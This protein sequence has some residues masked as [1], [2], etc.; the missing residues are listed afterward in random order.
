[1]GDNKQPL[2]SIVTPSYNQGQFIEETIRSVLLQN[3]PNIEYIIVDGGSTDNSLDIIKKYASRL[4]WFVS[5]KDSGQ[6]QAI[7]KGFQQ[8]K[9]KYV[10][11][12]NSDDIYLQGAI[13]KAVT[14]LEKNRNLGL[15]Y[16]N[17]LSIDA[18]THV[19]NLMHFQDWKLPDLMKFRII[20]QPAV[21]MR[22]VALEKTGFLD[23]QFSFLMDHHLWTRIA[24]DYPIQFV[25]DFWAGARFHTDAKN[26]SQA[27]G[28]GEEAGTVLA[29][30]QNDP[31]LR[32]YFDRY[33]K[34]ILAGYCLFDARYLLDGEEYGRALRQYMQSMRHHLPTAFQEI[35]R[36]LYAVVGM[37]FPMKSIREKF[38]Q[39]RSKKIH[40]QQFE[41]LLQYIKK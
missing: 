20:S 11:W 27:V 23:D 29:W 1:M 16:A 10:A 37:V 2:V 8:A 25:D 32:E 12:L 22:M 36:I 21:F 28:F 4:A 13:T 34:E 39:N 7:N 30:M 40:S 31:R 26:I 3:Y 24:I 14:V 9:G 33:R 18:E 41:P 17:T 35:R 6:A 15:V 38:I 5:E 19:F